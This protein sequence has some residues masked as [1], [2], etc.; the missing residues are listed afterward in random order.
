MIILPKLDINWEQ[1]HQVGG[2]SLIF[3][4]T[5]YVYS[6]FFLGRQQSV[7]PGLLF[8]GISRVVTPKMDGTTRCYNAFDQVP[9]HGRL[10][11]RVPLSKRN[12]R[13]RA[14]Q[15]QGFD[16]GLSPTLG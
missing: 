4:H 15:P 13:H 2:K 16:P 8:T 1:I 3:R 12:G 9:L 14:M 11:P 7:D 6:C 5:Q 10:M